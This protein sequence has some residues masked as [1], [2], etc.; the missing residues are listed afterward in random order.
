MPKLTKRLH[1]ILLKLGEKEWQGVQSLL[2]DSLTDSA[3]ELL[4]RLIADEIDR[5]R[6]FAARYGGN[7]KPAGKKETREAK[8]DMA[9]ERLKKMSDA[10]LS[11][12]LIEIGYS[13]PDKEKEGAPG[14]WEEYRVL[15][16]PETGQRK[17]IERHFI[18]ASSET[19][20]RRDIFTLDELIEDL[21][22]EK[23]L[24]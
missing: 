22:K 6:D 14:T 9:A 23:K 12:Y 7:F 13:P 18:R 3:P 17:Y 11:A 20:Y 15:T 8:A 1:S 16:E 24:L 5:R 2:E 19:A 21:K 4:R 10:S